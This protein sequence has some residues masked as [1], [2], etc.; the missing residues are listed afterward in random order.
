MSD[1]EGDFSDKDV[2]VLEANSSSSIGSGRKTESYE[3]TVFSTVH[4][5]MFN[6]SYI[7]LH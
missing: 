7:L 2:Y 1:T 6:N 3:C 5:Y 4:P